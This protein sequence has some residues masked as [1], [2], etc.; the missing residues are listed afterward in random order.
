[1]PEDE[2]SCR[3]PRPDLVK[4]AAKQLNFDPGDAFVIGDK[5]CDVELGQRVGATTFLVRT[6]YGTQVAA[7]ALSDPDYIVD[8]MRE[9][10]H[11]IEQLLAS[12]RG[13]TTNATKP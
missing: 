10:A 1:M 11:V 7:E 9:A 12:N 3:K 6:G 8:D 4:Q 5:P 13:R 2:C